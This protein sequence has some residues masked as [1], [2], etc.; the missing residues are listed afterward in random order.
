VDFTLI[1]VAFAISMPATIAVILR[2]MPSGSPRELA[3]REVEYKEKVLAFDEK[4]LAF[5]QQKIGLA[6][7]EMQMKE[8]DH[9]LKVQAHRLQNEI[10]QA[11]FE[12]FGVRGQRTTIPRAALNGAR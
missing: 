12:Q 10:K 8:A 9:A 1:A 4:K 3:L 7:R 2:F 5:E 11:E 6:E